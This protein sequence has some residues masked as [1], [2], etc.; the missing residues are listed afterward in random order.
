MWI[1]RI[2]AVMSFV[3][4]AALSACGDVGVSAAESTNIAPL[5]LAASTQ[6]LSGSS[7]DYCDDE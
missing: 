7:Q 5:S 4:T 3:L 6:M 1:K 2:A